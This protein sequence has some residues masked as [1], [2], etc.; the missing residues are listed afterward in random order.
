MIDLTSYK[1]YVERFL[2]AKKCDGDDEVYVGFCNFK[3][4]FIV[5]SRHRRRSSTIE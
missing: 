3:F 1:I 5:K 4:R 2:C